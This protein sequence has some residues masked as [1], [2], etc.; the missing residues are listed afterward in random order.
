MRILADE[1]IGRTIVD[2]LRHDGIDV[3]WVA[4]TC[5]GAN[6]ETVLACAV[7]T[8]RV[9]LTVDKDFGELTVRLKRPTVG[10]IIIALADAAAAE[11][12]DRTAHVLQELHGWAEPALTII[13]AKRVRRRRL[14][15]TLGG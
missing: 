9:L 3:A 5:P 8:G 15:G 10:V 2:R 13:E 11:I 4:E 1:C 6:D 12:A 7:D 14:G